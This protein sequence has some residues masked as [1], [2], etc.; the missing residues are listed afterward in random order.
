MPTDHERPAIRT[1]DSR[2]VYQDSWI[3]LRQDQIE[4]RD[5]SQGTYAVVEKRDS[6]LAAYALLLLHQKR[7]TACPE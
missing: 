4:R 1:L 3:R 2:V 7:P 5:G 6:T